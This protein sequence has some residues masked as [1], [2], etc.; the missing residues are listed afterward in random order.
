MVF[1]KPFAFIIRHFKAFH[2]VIF[3]TSLFIMYNANQVRSLVRS[4]ISQGAFTYVGAENYAKSPVY[5]IALIGLTAVGLIYWLFSVR[6]KD[7]KFYTFLLIYY[8]FSVGG[9]YYLFDKLVV[10]SQKE[11]T[12]DELNLI[13][14]V[15]TMILLVS[16]PVIVMSFIRSIGLNIKQFNFSKDIKELEITDKDSEEFEILIGQNNYKYLRKIRKTIREA[17]YVILEHI[18]FISIS[19]GILLLIGTI[20]FSYKYYKDHKSIGVQE[21]TTVNGVYYAVNNTYITARNLNGKQL[22]PNYK[23]VIL[24]IS[25][26]NMSNVKK[27]YDLNIFSLQTGRLIYKPISFYQ[28][29][30]K[31]LGMYIQNGTEIPTDSFLSGLLI[32]EIP[33][34]MNVTNYS[35]KIFRDYRITDEDFFVNY[36]KFAANGYI[37]DEEKKEETLNIGTSY[38]SSIYKDNKVEFTINKAYLSDSYNEKYIIC[39][40]EDKCN[41]KT[42]LIK[43]EDLTNS[44]ILVVEYSGSINSDAK[45]YQSIKDMDEFFN[46]FTYVEYTVGVDKYQSTKNVLY[47]GLNGKAF[48]II[49]RKATK[50]SSIDLVFSFRNSTIKVPI[51]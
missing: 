43:P 31:D 12:M 18:F 5:I 3:L 13:R 36:E 50:A 2:V 23:Y 9:F 51:K 11:V 37:L 1:R 41:T 7:L 39:E 21:I 19:A 22:K 40:T 10:L 33:I 6:K 45:Y 42:Y 4:L 24:N 47:K 49:D 48:I 29:E 30:F 25:M 27:L 20:G 15:S 38:N 32:F 34:T 44:T 28:E 35:L 17:K 16:L 14:D 26:K 46:S 8:I